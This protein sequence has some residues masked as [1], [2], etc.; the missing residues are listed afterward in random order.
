MN[1]LFKYRLLIFVASFSFFKIVFSD[2][3]RLN[4]ADPFPIFS[5]QGRY[6][7]L[8]R[9]SRDQI[10]EF[11]FNEENFDPKNDSE[12]KI[13]HANF[14][15]YVQT[16]CHGTDYLGNNKV[17]LC[18]NKNLSAVA[19]DTTNIIQETMP[20]QGN[21]QQGAPNQNATAN[22][23]YSVPMPLGA[24]PEPFNFFALFYPNNPADPIE[25]QVYKTGELLQAEYD[26]IDTQ[27]TEDLIAAQ[28]NVPAP[29]GAS[30]FNQVAKVVA[31]YL[32]FNDSPAFLVA[33]KGDIGNNDPAEAIGITLPSNL[34]YDYSNY[35]NN[36]FGLL[37]YPASRDPKKLFGYGYFN[38]NYQ[39][40]G[41]RGTFEWKINNNFGI[42]IYTGFSN[43]DI[44]TINIIDT[45]I[46]YQGPTAALMFSRYPDSIYQ[47]TNNNSPQ[48]PT[49]YEQPNM[50]ALTPYRSPIMDNTSNAIFNN[51]FNNSSELQ[52]YTPDEFKTAFLQ[53]IQYN[54]DSL[55]QLTNQ[56]FR[57]Y[58]A[59][60]FDDTTFEL[61]Y[62]RLIIYNKLPKNKLHHEQ[63]EENAKLVHIPYTLLPTASIHVTC[64]IA[65]RVPG[66]KI[67]GK[68][69][70][71]NGHWELGANLGLEFDFINNIILGTDVGFSWYN[72]S[73]YTNVPIPTNQFNEGIYL[74]NANLI[75]TPGYSYTVACGMQVD[76][77]FHCIDFFTEYR[78][79]RHAEDSFSIQSIN[80][81]L[82]I[83][84]MENTHTTPAQDE[85]DTLDTIPNGILYLN[86][87]QK[88]PYPDTAIIEHMKEVSSWTVQMINVTINYKINTDMNLG[89]AWQQPFLLR[90][91]Y[92]A[93]TLGI[94]FEMYL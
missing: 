49:P 58:A 67:F 71:N 16:A 11:I 70:D 84:Y 77:L 31:R 6:D 2:P 5:S 61:F 91:A 81:L 85:Y 93:S 46:N 1:F 4:N 78:L 23:F 73:L 86:Y 30:N 82:P 10:K 40:I 41:I 17:T 47:L 76:E 7:N 51:N 45:T 37:Q 36:Y 44:N 62:R 32:G 94:S 72:E 18:N 60:S 14:M 15:P 59:Q 35:K 65:P 54:L 12:D 26:Y 33:N 21:A 27:N 74:Y 52:N 79:V 22:I 42:K 8:T 43:L 80:N 89:F 38:T 19:V 55:G 66:N 87:N 20:T 69:I 92:N 68:P 28:Q 53:N 64:P 25:P 9:I 57:P 29:S 34:M 56:N 83:K 39:K 24:I 90:N 88:P 48:A 75:K 13:F 3:L 50:Y 63:N